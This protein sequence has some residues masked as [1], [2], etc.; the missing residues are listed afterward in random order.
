MKPDENT[1][2]STDTQDAFWLVWT[3][4]GGHPKHK[5]GIR[6]SAEKEA[7]RLAKQHPEK[8]FYVLKCVSKTFVESKINKVNYE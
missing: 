3:P 6:E 2:E 8:E 1:T 5:H 7:E 4:Q